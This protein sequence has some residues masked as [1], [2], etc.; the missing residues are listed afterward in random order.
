[1][2]DPHTHHNHTHDCRRFLDGLSDYVDGT[3]GEDL[4]RELEAHMATCENC[5]V[6]VNTFSKTVELY[7]Q[8]PAPELPDSVRE[9][10]YKVLDLKPFVLPDAPDTSGNQ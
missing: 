6:V 5:R 3:L 2:S 8:L 9:R 7:H 10:L 4:C 1:M